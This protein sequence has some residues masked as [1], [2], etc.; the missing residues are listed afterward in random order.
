MPRDALIAIGGGL[1][2]AVAA[3]AF[4]GGSAMALMLVYFAPIPLLMVGFGLGPRA[5]TIA[6]LIGF[7]A[8]GLFGGA[9]IAGFY[10]FIHALPAWAIVTLVMR[11]DEAQHERKGDGW[12]SPGTALSAIALLGGGALLAVSIGAGDSGLEGLIATH[13]DSAFAGMAP[14]MGA[15][16]RGELVAVLTPVFPG[17]LGASWAAMTVLNGVIA[18]G[19]LV[20]VGRNLRPS[21]LYADLA[22][23]NWASWPLV[24]A[25]A[26]AVAGS[27]LGHGELGYVGRNMAMVFAAPYFFLG[28]AVV[29]TLAR[30]VAFTGPVLVAL[31]MVILVSGW[32]AVVVA[33]IGIAEQWVGLRHRSPNGTAD[34]GPENEE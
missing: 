17:A 7:F 3:V 14:N 9:M 28:L 6:A 16:D 18:Q 20:R 19:F 33:G 31:Y 5:A 1:M 10:G 34:A 30:R 25:A 32:A 12:Q 2:S 21:P 13:L 29:H 27:G 4:L 8:T 11:K 22:L 26:A 23:P 24:I 15:A